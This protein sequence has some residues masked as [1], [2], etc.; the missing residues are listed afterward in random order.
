MQ[1]D[2][3]EPELGTAA[4]MALPASRETC[5]RMVA[6]A[7]SPVDGVAVAVVEPDRDA[8][9]IIII[10][11]VAGDASIWSP[12]TYAGSRTRSVP[13]P[14]PRA[15]ERPGSI[16]QD[17]SSSVAGGD[18]AWTSSETKEYLDG[19]ALVAAAIA[20]PLPRGNV[21]TATLA[22]ANERTAG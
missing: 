12:C 13:L 3:Y 19:F 5:A 14:P 17:R 6:R 9:V 18:V 16:A 8:Y 2:T 22:I 1:T 21:G 4:V 10:M 20:R 15:S 7:T 11:I